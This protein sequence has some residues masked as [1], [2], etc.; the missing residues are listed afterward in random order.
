MAVCQESV[1]AQPKSKSISV[2]ELI[3]DGILWA[4]PRNRR[5]IEKRWKRKY[6]ALDYVWKMLVPKRNIRVCNNCGH[7][8]EMGVLCRKLNCLSIYPI[9]SMLIET[10]FS[11]LA[12]CYDKVKQE[13]K[14]IQE[15]IQSELGLSPVETDVIVLYDGERN[16]QVNNRKCKFIY[17]F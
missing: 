9:Y 13:T 3:G 11:N 14:K 1:L 5:T 15:K 10:F 6:G 16:E 17:K 4:V 2:K 7:H 8:H 12:H